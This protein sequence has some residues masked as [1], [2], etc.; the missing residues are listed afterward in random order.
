MSQ[1]SQ[2]RGSQLKSTNLADYVGS[3]D[4]D[5]PIRYEPEYE[6]KEGVCAHET[7]EADF[8]QPTYIIRKMFLALKKKKY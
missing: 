4:C 5:S 3:T 7:E 2:T 1:V 8:E 6:E